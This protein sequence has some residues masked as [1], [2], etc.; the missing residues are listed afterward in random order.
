MSGP[1]AFGVASQH[2]RALNHLSRFKQVPPRQAFLRRPRY[3][4]GAGSSGDTWSSGD[5]CIFFL[6][7]CADRPVCRSGTSQSRDPANAD[8]EYCDF[9][10]E[11]L[12]ARGG[13][14]CL[15]PN[16]HLIRRPK[17]PRGSA[18]RSARPV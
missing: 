11:A 8:Y 16:L 5:T 10:R 15:M 7:P 13:G 4:R 6:F 9:H 3:R 12:R 2:R 18:G 17:R 14:C 1:C